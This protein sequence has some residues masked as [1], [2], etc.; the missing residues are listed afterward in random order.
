[1][2]KLALLLSVVILL[3]SSAWATPADVKRAK[4]AIADI[5]KSEQELSRSVKKL[6]QLERKNLKGATRGVDSDGDGLADV[7]EGVLGSKR[8]D[9]DSD[10]DGVD[11]NTDID[12]DNSDSDGDGVPDGME[13]E[14]KGKIVSFNDPVLVIGTTSL[15]ITSTTVFFRGLT[16]KA[17]LTAG[18]CVEAEGRRSGGT[19]L[20]DKIKRQKDSDCGSSSGN[21]D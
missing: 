6:T 11:D 5:K 17:D 1:M 9:A 13:V 4:R 2:H 19:I 20:V 3:I 8:C 16:S 12:E 7:L 21:D 14:T 10:D 18:I 15:N